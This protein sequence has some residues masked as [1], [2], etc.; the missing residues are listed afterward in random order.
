MH[1]I[2]KES[3][4]VIALDNYNLAFIPHIFNAAL[5]IAG[6]S[7]MVASL[8]GVT[9]ILVTLSEEGDAPAVFS[10]KGKLSVPWPTLLITLAGISLSIVAALLM[11]G[12]IYEYVTT[13]AGLM[14]LY[15]WMFILASSIRLLEITAKG[16]IKYSIGILLILI[17]VSGTLFHATSRPGFFISIV[18]VGT[19]GIITFFMRFKWKKK[20]KK[21]Y[22]PW[23]TA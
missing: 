17:A 2:G 12:K 18:F 1:S 10:K 16:K 9:S 20:K 8:F 13:A 14:L 7:T 11:P 3:S 5:I 19:I 4:F 23:P 6:F 15:N 21:V 22:S